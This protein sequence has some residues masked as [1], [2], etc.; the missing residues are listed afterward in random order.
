MS[1]GVKNGEICLCNPNEISLLIRLDIRSA[2][3]SVFVVRCLSCHV[4]QLRDVYSAGSKGQFKEHVHFAIFVVI[5]MFPRFR[6]IMY[7]F[8]IDTLQ[9]TWWA[10]YYKLIS[11]VYLKRAYGALVYT[12]ISPIFIWNASQIALCWHM[13]KE[14]SISEWEMYFSGVPLTLQHWM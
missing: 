12:Y 4:M 3:V 5:W 2:F 11:Y 8:V 14:N 7:C 10:S 6:I 13:M 1:H 9:Y